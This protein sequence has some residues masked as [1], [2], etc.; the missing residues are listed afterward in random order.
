MTPKSFKIT[1]NRVIFFGFLLNF[2]SILLFLANR[3][4]ASELYEMLGFSSAQAPIP[5]N[6]EDMFILDVSINGCTAYNY[7]NP[8]CGKPKSGDGKFGDLT[9]YG[10]DWIRV[11]KDLCLGL[12]WF[13]KEVLWVKKISRTDYRKVLD[14][15]HLTDEVV[16]DISVQDPEPEFDI[17]T[18]QE[19]NKKE[20]EYRSN[21]VWLKYGP[22]NDKN[23]VT[24]VDVLFGQDA[25]DP[26]PDWNF[27]ESSI[28][29]VCGIVG[30]SAFITF[31]KGPKVDYKRHYNKPLVMNDKDEFKILQVADLHFSTGIGVCFNAEPPSSTIGC[32]ADPRTLEFIGKVLDI[33][34]PDLVVL[35]GDQIFGLTAP[36][37]ATAALKAYSPFIERKIPFAAVLGNHDAEGSLAA[38]ELMQLFADLPY[39]VGVVGPETIDGYGNYVTTVQGKSNSSVALAFYFVDS[40]DYSQNKKEYPGYDW[41]K[42]NQLK[43]MKEQAES[44]KDGVAEFEKEKVKQNGKIKNKTH[45]SMAFFHIPLPEFKNTTETLVGTPREDSGSPKYNSGARDAFQEIGVKAISIGHDHCNDYCLLDKRQSPT[46]ENQIWLCYA[47]GVGLGGYGC[48]GYQRRTR[49]YVFNTAK[50]EIKSWKRAENEPEVR[51]DE[52]ILVSEGVIGNWL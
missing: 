9:A 40:H 30:Y 46:E 45:L 18:E 7:R 51:I 22:H 14:E 37:S 1:P 26:R 12:S 4:Y 13:R 17:S 39:S 35:S 5:T 48:K 50:G 15:T 27:V 25:V 20:W 41:I 49:T 47:G 24:A 2:I 10:A 52:Q 8:D 19:L 34:Q 3:H 29:D 23:V 42:E 44:I 32:R 6:S 21:N 36:D 38:K 11:D 33:E 28:K 16:I 31:R 43:Y